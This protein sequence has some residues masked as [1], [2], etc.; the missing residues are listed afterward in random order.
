MF[1]PIFGLIAA[2]VIC[3]IGLFILTQSR[4]SR[5]GFAL[6]IIGLVFLMKPAFGH[7]HS[8]PELNGWLKSL[9]SKSNTWCCDGS[10]TDA[11]DDWETKG[12]GYRVKFEGRWFDV[13][14][15]AIVD[16]PNK[17]GGPLLWMSKGWGEREVRCFMPGSLT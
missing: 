5:V 10:D 6:V 17:S 7:D 16:G 1:P 2:A 8:R 9:H 12:S 14:D 13:P 3:I 4:G 11:I 15:S